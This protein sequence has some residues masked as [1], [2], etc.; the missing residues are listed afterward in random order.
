MTP[1]EFI[2]KYEYVADIV[3]GSYKKRNSS[4]DFHDLKQ[5]ALTKMFKSYPR[6]DKEKSSLRTFG[7]RYANFG[8]LDYLKRENPYYDKKIPIDENKNIKDKQPADPGHEEYLTSKRE[9]ELLSL[10]IEKLDA[11]KQRILRWRYYYDIQN[12]EIARREGVSSPR[13]SQLHTRSLIELSICLKKLGF[14]REEFMEK[15]KGEASEEE[16]KA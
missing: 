5:V 6:Y 12:Q 10:C 11:R 9:K 3:A 1:D 8:I 16:K 13:I 14:S 4:L 15:E 7:Y 2:K